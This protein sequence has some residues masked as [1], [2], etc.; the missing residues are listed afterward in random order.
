MCGFGGRLLEILAAEGG[1]AAARRR[2]GAAR[3]SLCTFFADS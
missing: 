1:C 3:V 2:R